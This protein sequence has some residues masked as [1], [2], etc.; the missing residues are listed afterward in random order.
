MTPGDYPLLEGID[1]PE[2]LRALSAGE[3]PALA[4]ELRDFLLHSVARSGGHLAAGLGVVELTIALHYV[5]QTPEDRLVWDVGHQCYPHKILTGRRER[6]GTVRKTDGLAGFPK[7]DESPYDTF[8][9]GHS[10][11]SLSA[12]IGMALAARARGDGRR[13]CAVIG[14]GGMTAGQAFEALNHAGDA[15]PDML[16]ILNDN[17]MSI[18]ENVGALS[19]T[20]ARLLAGGLY[21]NL[22]RESKRVLE[23]MPPAMREFARRAEAHAKGM[24]VPGTFFEE[25]GFQY[26]GPVDGHDLSALLPVLRR[27]RTTPGPLLL[28]VVTRKGKGYALAEEDPI[29]YHGVKAFDPAEGL[30][31]GSGG[32]R[33]S[34]TQVFGEWLCDIAERDSRVWGI[35]PAMREGSGL[36]EFARRFP[37]RYLDVGIAEQHSVTLAA[38]L[39]CEGERPVLAIYSTFLQRGYDQLIHDIALQEL[40]VLLALDR[41]GL[42]GADGPTHNGSFDLSY[43]RCIP[44]LVV[45]A[46][47]DENECR[48]MLY[49]G[50]RHDGPAAVRYPR[51]TGPGVTVS[52]EMQAL[53]IGRAEPR[54]NGHRVA[55]LAFGSMLAPALAAAERLDATVINMRFV[56]PVD[57]DAVLKAAATH[58]LLVT[59][60]ENVIAGGAGSAVAEALDAAGETAVCRHIGLPDRFTDHGDPATLLSRLGLDADG[61]A[62]QVGE[63]LGSEKAAATDTGRGR[64]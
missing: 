4:R 40:P 26:F 22:R 12:A 17:E 15:R 48:Q 23:H 60:E 34:Y 42:V 16:V 53:P 1:S 61:I 5:Y 19:R 55:L 2:A 52:P 57:E 62:A 7:R 43:L 39:A 38:G 18:S 10:S 29:A 37:G 59:V 50:Y 27:L 58:E 45:M 44:N 46:P 3:L 6:I 63:W 24:V 54:R 33:P 13:V 21:G 28:H 31:G 32:G 11:T 8:G 9:V 51:G 56:K 36:V 64:G 47:A 25:L 41:A 20:F 49:T 30:T 35:T 14:D